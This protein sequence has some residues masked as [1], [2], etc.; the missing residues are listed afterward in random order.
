MWWSWMSEPVQPRRRRGVNVQSDQDVVTALR[1][2]LEDLLRKH[3]P[4]GRKLHYHVVKV[5]LTG[6]QEAP[7]GS[8]EWYE[9]MAT[10]VAHVR[11]VN[12][13]VM[14]L[15]FEDLKIDEVGRVVVLVEMLWQAREATT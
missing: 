5:A 10:M 1:S 2:R 11:K 3:N 14:R 6:T 12:A 13:Q 15:C 7:D 8:V 4:P 9:R